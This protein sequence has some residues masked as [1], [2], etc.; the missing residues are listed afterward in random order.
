MLIDGRT[1]VFGIIGNPVVHSLSPLMHN[2]AFDICG[3][4][5]VYVPLHTDDLEAALEGIRGMRIDGLSVTIPFKEQVMKLLDE[6]D[7]VALK[8]GAVNTVVARRDGHSAHLYGTNTDWLGSNRALADHI[9]LAGSRAVILGSGGAARAVGF[10]LLEAGAEVEIKSRN[11]VKGGALAEQLGAAWSPLDRAPLKDAQILINA[12][13][14]GMEPEDGVSP[15]ASELLSG[16]GVVMDIVYAPLQTRLLKEAVE[17]GCVAVNGLEMLLYQGV[18]QFELWTG[19]EAP[20]DA[21]REEL[22]EAVS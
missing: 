13:S 6:I 22:L 3:N 20:V 9:E 16:Y 7:P 11:E 21:M 17:H 2:R 1:K 18:A 4:N 19:L 10:G 15:L 5:G 14:V 8:I 12:T